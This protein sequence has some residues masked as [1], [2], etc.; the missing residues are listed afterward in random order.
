MLIISTQRIIF[1]PYVSVFYNYEEKVFRAKVRH[2][3]FKD[4][5]Y[6]EEFLE[7]KDMFS[8][9]GVEVNTTGK[10]AVERILKIFVNQSLNKNEKANKILDVIEK[11]V[12][13]TFSFRI[14]ESY[15]NS[16]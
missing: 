4:T 11:S 3:K 10:A 1:F 16:F 14:K 15:T 9:V 6:S 2:D 13:R 8:Q 7:L 5:W 12:K